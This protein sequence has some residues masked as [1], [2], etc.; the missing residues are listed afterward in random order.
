MGEILSLSLT[1][2]KT[3]NT[4]ILRRE[5]K[6]IQFNDFDFDSFFVLSHEKL[7]KK[8][9]LIFSQSLL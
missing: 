4:K 9:F 6:N 2:S 8:I 7:K 5:E 1:H 3:I